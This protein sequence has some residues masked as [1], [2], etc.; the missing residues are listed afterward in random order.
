MHAP[1]RTFLLGCLLAVPC[2][3]AQPAPYAYEGLRFERSVRVAD[4]DLVLNGTGLRGVKWLKVYLVALYLRQPA[5]SAAAALAMAG[6][7]RLQLRML[8]EAPAAEFVKAFNNGV[9]RNAPAAELPLLSERMQ[10][11]GRSVAALGKVRAGDVVDLDLLPG[12]GTLFAL[13]GRLQ[14]EAVVG[15][16]FFAALLRAFIGERPYDARMRAGLLGPLR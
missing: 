1:R 16:D 5:S 10:A 4:T 6:P 2:L 11:F 13:N 9:T 7:K 15:D 12:R 8:R 3:R 14:A